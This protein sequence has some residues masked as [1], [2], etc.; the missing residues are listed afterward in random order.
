VFIESTR[1]ATVPLAGELWGELLREKILLM[2][3]VMARR[4]LLDPLVARGF[5][6]LERYAQLLANAVDLRDVIANP[7]LDSGL[8]EVLSMFLPEN[9]AVKAG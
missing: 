3:R 9:L 6:F 4:D 2:D 1:L 8:S 7:T 5:G